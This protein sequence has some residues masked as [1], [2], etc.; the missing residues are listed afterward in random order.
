MPDWDSKWSGAKSNSTKNCIQNYIIFVHIFHVIF[1]FCVSLLLSYDYFAPFCSSALMRLVVRAC[2]LFMYVCDFMHKIQASKF[3]KGFNGNLKKKWFRMKIFSRIF[4]FFRVVCALFHSIS[5]TYTHGTVTH[6]IACSRLYHRKRRQN[7]IVQYEWKIC[8]ILCMWADCNSDSKVSRTHNQIYLKKKS[9]NNDERTGNN[10]NSPFSSLFFFMLLFTIILY[11]II[12][13]NV[14]LNIAHIP[15]D[16]E[17]MRVIQRKKNKIE[18]PELWKDWNFCVFSFFFKS[19]FSL[20]LRF[21]VQIRKSASLLRSLSAQLPLR[22]FCYFFLLIE[23]LYF[24]EQK[25]SQMNKK[26]NSNNTHTQ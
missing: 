4:F 3:Q 25:S 9:W 7:Q 24:I 22:I 13:W 11:F 17:K 2:E 10:N 5:Y 18:I 23:L 19:V 26:K 6:C 16:S 20:S 1:F 15:F 21:S 14:K 8:F 12:I